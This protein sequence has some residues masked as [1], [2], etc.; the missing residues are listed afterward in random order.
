MVPHRR[1]SLEQDPDL[2]SGIDLGGLPRAVRAE[3]RGL[4]PE[5][6]EFVGGHLVMAGELIDTDPQLAFAHAEAARRRASRLPVV[7]E[8]SAETA[9]AAGE[10]AHALREYR[11]LRRM[12]GGVEYLPVMADCE[13]ALGRHDDA[14]ALIREAASSPELGPDSR[15][16]ALM[17]EAGVRED[18]GQT[19]E[20]VRLLKQATRTPA[21]GLSRDSAA[22]LTYAYADLLLRTGDE[23]GAITWFTRTVDLDRGH[24]TDAGD[25]LATLQGMVLEVDEAGIEPWAPE[26]SEDADDASADEGQAGQADERPL[27]ENE[28]V[29]ADEQDEDAGTADERL[30]QQGAGEEDDVAEDEDVVVTTGAGSSSTL[31]AGAPVGDRAEIGSE[32]GAA[33][34]GDALVDSELAGDEQT[35]AEHDL[36]GEEEALADS[37]LAGDDP[38]VGDDPAED[39]D[40]PVE[41]ELGADEETLADD[42]LADDELAGDDADALVADESDEPVDDPTVGTADEDA[43]ADGDDR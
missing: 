41:V 33:P 19:K 22:R 34:D 25:R 26:E 18:M 15:A 14:L 35:L 20:A 43:A 11:A 2:P 36:G 1:T 40:G 9:Y 8:A 27:D 32:A 21:R 7:R 16:E 39:E 31:D 38:Q 23:A 5:S 3:L 10:Y 37:A 17:V 13:R 42:E 24:V 30:D 29:L 28:D 4:S 12:T 6:A